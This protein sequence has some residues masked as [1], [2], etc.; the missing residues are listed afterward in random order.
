M[1]TTDQTFPSSS[2]PP[3]A[4]T[5]PRRLLRSR[6]DRVVAG[7]AGGIA[8]YTGVPALLVRLLVVAS[9]FMGW[10]WLAYPV[11]WIAMPEE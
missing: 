3:A 1:T 8:E 10:G 5:G 6:S 9:L 11:L 7:V 4:R 2:T